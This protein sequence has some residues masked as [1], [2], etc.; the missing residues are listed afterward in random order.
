M[1]HWWTFFYVEILL[2]FATKKVVHEELLFFHVFPAGSSSGRLAPNS[3]SGS[4][5]REINATWDVKSGEL[6]PTQVAN[7]DDDLIRGRCS[8]DSC[9][10]QVFGYS[11]VISCLLADITCITWFVCIQYIYNYIYIYIYINIMSR[12][13]WQNPCLGHLPVIRRGKATRT[14]AL[15][16]TGEEAS[17]ALR[18]V[19]NLGGK[20]V[21]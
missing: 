4:S 2:C 3:D 20:M 13:P 15:R 6:R 14:R 7:C 17:P 9:F 5:C 21:V 10:P 8:N 12:F 1:I 19:Q 18:V 11:D 16:R